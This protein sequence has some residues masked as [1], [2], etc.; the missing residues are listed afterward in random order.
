LGCS[1]LLGS[2]PGGANLIAQG[3]PAAYTYCCAE[4][5]ADSPWPGLH[6]DLGFADTTT[7]TVLR[8]EGPHNLTDQE[9]TEPTALLDTFAST[10]TGWAA[11]AAYVPHTETALLLNPEHAILLA[12]AGWT[13][14][15]IQQYLFET[16]RSQWSAARDQRPS[17][18]RR[19]A[20][21]ER[22]QSPSHEG[23]E[24]CC[25]V[26]GQSHQATL[27]QRMVGAH[28]PAPLVAV[29]SV[30]VQPPT[31]A[32][33]GRPP[34]QPPEVTGRQGEQCCHPRQPNRTKQHRWSSSSARWNSGIQAS[35]RTGAGP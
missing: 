9:S 28:A 30:P 35:A 11:N 32:T 27:V 6:A 29:G 4:N 23:F 13:K 3:S 5:L 26:A 8:C 18:R 24:Q 17:S 7:V 14:H 31:T 21:H 34:C 22:S 19:G 15:D 16:A 10:M 1:F 25:H 2:L 20:T 33:R 12:D